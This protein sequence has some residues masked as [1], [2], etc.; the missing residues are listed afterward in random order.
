MNEH[1]EGA[2]T[3]AA[4]DVD[5][6]VDAPGFF[7]DPYPAYAALRERA[8]MVWSEQWGGWV[9]TR[10]D[11]VAAILR[12]PTRYSSAGRIHYI[13]DRLP[14]EVRE[15][16]ALLEAHYSV[17]IAHVDPPAHTRLRAILTPW[18]TPKLMESLRSRIR[19]LAHSL[20]KHAAEKAREGENV[21]FMHEVAYPLPA[22]V[23]LELL[24]APTSDAPLFHQWAL[25]V[26]QLFAGG[27]RTTVARMRAAQQGLRDMRVYVGDLIAARRR[28]SH[29]DLLGRL[30]DA[31]QE[32][33]RLSDDE[34]ISTAVTLF[35]AG[36]ETTTNLLG[37][38]V[39]AL[40]RNPAQLEK[41]RANPA[42]LPSAVEEMLRYD[43]PVQRSWRIA[44][45]DHMLL[46]Q[47]V[48][49]GEL[50]LVLIGAAHRDPSHFAD[51]DAFDIAR[52]PN[53]HMG[54]GYGIHFCLG[55]PLARI[56]APEVLTALLDAFP[57]MAL[58]ERAPLR[59]R[60]DI[61]LRGV[62]ELPL[63][64]QFAQVAA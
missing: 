41:L 33:E 38:G 8:P 16:T 57:S 43:T 26:N 35:V 25:D 56:E 18:F 64:G 55:A 59:W 50:L 23:V 20:C 9:L 63:V 14:P 46:G 53:R 10:Y 34:L 17:G 29:N 27:G 45:E 48:R 40:L 24:G 22:T 11:D 60:E 36:H 58:D 3:R 30:V 49:A 51:P 7:D 21:D 1:V 47:Q 42:L 6:L 4:V 5:A 62:E 2:S 32:G 28:N 13:L 37:N 15:E 44:T 52:T 54:F 19:E 12:N 61:A 31:E 39:V